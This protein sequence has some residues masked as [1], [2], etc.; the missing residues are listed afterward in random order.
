MF[1][2]FND[3]GKEKKSSPDPEYLSL[4]KKWEDFLSKIENRFNESL[5]QAEA[6]LIE[7]L[8]ESDYDL[9][10]TLIA[11]QGMKSQI[12]GLADKV[13]ETF[14]KKVEPKM[15]Q[16]IESWELIEESQKGDELREKIFT[17]LERFQQV[18]EGKISIKFYNHAIQYLNTDFNCSQCNAQLEVKKDIFRSHYVSCEYCNTVNTFLPNKKIAQISWVVDNIARYKALIQWDEKQQHLNEYQK[19]RADSSGDELKK[20]IDA[21]KKREESERAYWKVFLTERYQFLP[22]YED[23]FEH[24]LE[25]KMKYVYEERKREFNF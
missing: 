9:T 10:P 16:Y 12:M 25:V 11:W 24:D 1:G 2:F 15:L 3:N 5:I 22:Q 8:T 7:N 19:Y 18:L 23:S 4:I 14:E 20:R 6:A 13:D 21:F 17:H